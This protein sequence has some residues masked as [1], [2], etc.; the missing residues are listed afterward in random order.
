MPLSLPYVDGISGFKSLTLYSSFEAA[1][2]NDLEKIKS[3]T[4][5][6]WGSDGGQPPL[7]IAVSDLKMNSPFSL[8]F[9]KGHFDTAKAILE[10]TQA[11]WS[12]PGGEKARFRIANIGDDD[13]SPA[14]SEASD[15]S[16]PNIFKEIVDDRFTIDKIGQVSM[17]VKS[18]VSASESL[19][20]TRSTFVIGEDNRIEKTYPGSSD[21]LT[22]VIT[23]ND[24]KRFHFLLDMHAR[25]AKLGIFPDKIFFH[26]IEL[27]RTRM[28]ARAIR[29]FGA[30][31]P[32][33]H[34]VKKSGKEVKVKPK[35][36]QGLTVYGKK[37]ADWAKR[38]RHVATRPRSQPP[39]LLIAAFKGS[40]ESCQWF[41]SDGPAIRYEKFGKSK[42]AREDPRLK[43]LNESPGGFNRAISK[44]LGVQS[45]CLW[46]R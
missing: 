28:L 29:E 43:H 32:I 25:F 21:L 19:G 7:A 45:E 1:W 37:R 11:Q 4:L 22:F 38:G 39:P 15:N 42:T 18:H 41:L 10:I 30:G 44:W 13:H 35:Y 2:A 8:A 14:D 6:P 34:L 12:P 40:L 31:I 9:L 46:K 5:A 20:W 17:K 36:Y 16:E 23:Q 26:A 33:E 24:T 27:G 3:L